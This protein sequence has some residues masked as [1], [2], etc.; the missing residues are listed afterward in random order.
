MSTFTASARFRQQWLLLGSMAIL[1]AVSWIHMTRM[2]G[3]MP[4]MPARDIPFGPTFTMWSVMMVAMMLP[5]VLPNLSAFAAYERKRLGGG[6]ASPYLYA[7]GYLLAWVGYAAAATLAQ[8]GLHALSLL[9]AS[10]HLDS[11]LLGGAVLLAAG[12]FQWSPW[13][14]SCL[15]YCRSPFGLLAGGW[16]PGSSAALRLGLRQGLYCIGCC[17]ALMLVMFVFGVMNIL[18]MALLTL[19]I[20]AEKVVGAPRRLAQATGLALAAGGLW[21][22][23]GA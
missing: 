7:A 15:R 13:K 14:A 20:L 10:K 6:S 21:L 19:L 9:S 16:P 12:A 23:I 3:M 17:W 2:A 5:G 8:Q 22:M 4:A 1:A 18:W 11:P